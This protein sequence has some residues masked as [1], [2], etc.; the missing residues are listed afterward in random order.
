MNKSEKREFCEAV[1][2]LFIIKTKF[3]GTRANTTNSLESGG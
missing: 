1:V 3:K 2:D